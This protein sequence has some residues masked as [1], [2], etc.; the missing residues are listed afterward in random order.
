MKKYIFM[1]LLGLSLSVPK[2]HAQWVV[3]D[4]GNFAGNIVNSV[5]E[6]ATASKTVKN[7]LDGFKVLMIE[8]DIEALSD[9]NY[10]PDSG[11]WYYIV[12]FLIGIVGYFCVPTVAGWI[13][14]AG[15]GIGSYGRNVNQTAQHGAQG[16][17]T[18]GKA[19]MAGAGAA[20]GNVGGRIKGALLKGK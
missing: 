16:A 9:P 17:Y 18:G 5:K 15:G 19:A 7:T 4:P 3:T 11:T 14:E 20:V 8:K 13:I 2:A 12:F 10:L 6:I 1:A